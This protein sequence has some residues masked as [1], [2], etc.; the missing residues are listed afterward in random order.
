M[1]CLST[2]QTKLTIF[3]T[4][5]KAL[6]IQ[7][8]WPYLL[9]A[10]N[11]CGASGSLISPNQVLIAVDVDLEAYYWINAQYLALTMEGC[12]SSK[13][14]IGLMNAGCNS[15]ARQLPVDLSP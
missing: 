5:S 11:R 7:A 9:I 2:R 12:Q 6:N 1:T 14:I 8:E 4:E 10:S 3:D 15:V 13:G